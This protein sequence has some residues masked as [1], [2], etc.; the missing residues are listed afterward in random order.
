MPEHRGSADAIGC[1][2]FSG[3]ENRSEAVSGWKVPYGLP[4]VLTSPQKK[5]RAL[6]VGQH[7][8][9]RGFVFLPPLRLEGCGIL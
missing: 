4:S 3:A 5:A 7:R 8:T 6:S 1:A 9:N 2:D